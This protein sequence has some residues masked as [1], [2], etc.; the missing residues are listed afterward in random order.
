MPGHR[1]AGW[2]RRA[3][4]ELRKSEGQAILEFVLVLPLVVTL[5]FVLVQLGITFNNYL[6]VT[7]AARVA[8]RAA[9]VA[10]LQGQPDPC[11]AATAAAAKV[12]TLGS[13]D[14]QVQCS[15]PNG[16]QPGDTVAI[17]VTHG[18]DVE[19]PLIGVSTGQGT[20][21]GTSTEALE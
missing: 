5:V 12:V 19:L 10:R 6:Q 16:S 20:L 8:A 3:I 17:T 15:F 11:A 21:K 18:W 7:D 13:S 1:I 9:A 2:S 14:F 4:G